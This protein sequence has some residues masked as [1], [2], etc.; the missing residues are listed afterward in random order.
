MER[1]RGGEGK[2]QMGLDHGCEGIEKEGAGG[3]RG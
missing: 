1:T 2:E 3:R